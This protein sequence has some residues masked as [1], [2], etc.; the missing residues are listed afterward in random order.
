MRSLTRVC[1]CAAK[2]LSIVLHLQ[3]ANN[4]IFLNIA[5][6]L[7]AFDIGKARDDKG[8]EIPVDIFDLSNGGAGPRV[9]E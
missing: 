7:W 3:L 2:I 8:N 1:I 6:M 9:R 4:S 5:R